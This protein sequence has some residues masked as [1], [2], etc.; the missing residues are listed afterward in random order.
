MADSRDPVV[1][2]KYS[3]RRLYDT[4]QS[5]YITL[6]DLAGIV[7]AGD[8]VKVVDA[9]GGTDLTRQVLTQ[10]ILEQQDRLDMMPVEL[11]H[12]IIRVQGTIQQAPLTAWL[13]GL[14][15]QL[16]STGGQLAEQMNQIFS[17]F[18]FGFGTPP[19]RPE[20]AVDP[21]AVTEPPPPDGDVDDKAELDELKQRMDALLERLGKDKQ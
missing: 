5:K 17:G 12:A 16:S 14:A 8:D 18:G 4:R 10:V 6:E 2:K 7:Q 1:I 11:L 21:D 15:Q 3:N 13:H 20:P 9:K 19:P